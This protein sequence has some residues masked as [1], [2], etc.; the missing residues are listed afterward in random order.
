[1]AAVISFQ[2]RGSPLD[3]LNFDTINDSATH[4]GLFRPFVSFEGD[5]EGL[6]RTEFALVASHKKNGLPRIFKQFE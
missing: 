2:M 3:T 5:W 4:Q 1:M 6:F